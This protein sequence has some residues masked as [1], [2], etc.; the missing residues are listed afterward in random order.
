MDRGLKSMMN[1]IEANLNKCTRCSMLGENHVQPSSFNGQ[2]LMVI[3]PPPIQQSTNLVDELL[4]YMLDEIGVD[5]E[6]V[7]FTHLIKCPSAGARSYVVEELNT[8][9]TTW[10]RN[11]I[12]LV[13]PVVV[14][15]L[16][17]LAWKI[18]APSLD[19]GHGDVKKR[20]DISY[21]FSYSPSYCLMSRKIDEL[22]KIGSKIKEMLNG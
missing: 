2:E 15:I 21:I 19:V 16:G 5:R 10:L 4:D 3:L 14:C 1:R 7:Y 12:K 6:D 17:E 11:E 13:R 18:V 22:L 9:Y 8:C 20:G